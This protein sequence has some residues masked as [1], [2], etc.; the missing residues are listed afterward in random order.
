MAGSVNKAIVVGNVGKD[1]DIKTTQSGKQIA[2]FS[3]A[4][5]ESWRDKATGEKKEKTEWHR[6]VVYNENIAKIVDQYV[7]KGSKLYVEGQLA[8]R[9]YSDKNNVERF[10]TEI[11]LQGFNGTLTLLDGRRDD[12]DA[13]GYDEE[14][15]NRFGT[16]SPSGSGSE[17]FPSS[18][19]PPTNY[20][21]TEIPF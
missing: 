19:P 6:V 1:P 17:S 15:A 18:E 2:M 3:L 13:G 10:T 4:T 14:T 7:K 8:T 16:S 20:A 5:S 12:R 11:V 21:D 9:K